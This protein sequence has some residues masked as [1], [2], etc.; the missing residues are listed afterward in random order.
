MTSRLQ[1]FVDVLGRVR[2]RGMP[3]LG[4]GSGGACVGAMVGLAASGAEPVRIH[5]AALGREGRL[6]IRVPSS[7]RH[8]YV[9]HRFAD[10]TSSTGRA[11]AIGNGVDGFTTLTEN[12]GAGDRGGFYRVLEYAR[13]APGDADADG[14]D[15]VTEMANPVRMSPL[16]PA[17]EIAFRDGTASIPDRATFKELSY[18]GDQVAIDVQLKGLEFVKFQIEKAD[19]PRP[20]LFF[21]NT[22]THRSHPSFMRAVGIS[23]GGGGGGRGSPGTMRGVMV[24]HPLLLA[25]NGEAGLYTIEFEPNDS[26]PF[27]RIQLAQELV[28][29]NAAVV[30]NNLGYHPIGPAVSRANQEKALYAASRIPVYF[31]ADLLP[32]NIGYLPLHTGQAFGRLR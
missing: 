13:D 20:E 3:A 2:S 15:D 14:K 6:E 1:A 12:L 21:I 7:S 31:D 23:A 17:K 4:L 32:R 5:D 8:Y 19:T 29:A 16:N 10:V 28:A 27:A 22:V 24:F 11:V 25:P 9:L 26:F 30:R 18:Q